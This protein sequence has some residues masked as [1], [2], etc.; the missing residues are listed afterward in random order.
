MMVGAAI[1]WCVMQLIMCYPPEI[2]CFCLFHYAWYFKE[3]LFKYYDQTWNHEPQFY[4]KPLGNLFFSRCH[5]P[6]FQ[7]INCHHKSSWF[8]IIYLHGHQISHET[9]F[10]FK[11]LYLSVSGQ[12]LNSPLDRNCLFLLFHVIKLKFFFLSSS[13]SYI[14]DTSYSE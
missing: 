9:S 11:N 13:R 7:W 2:R 6:K 5:L 3:T 14:H 4:C 1:T 8:E 12:N 10:H